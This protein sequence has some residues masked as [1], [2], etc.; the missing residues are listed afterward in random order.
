MA[1]RPPVGDPSYNKDE[2]WLLNKTL[3]G[4]RWSP[5]HRYNMIT[6]IL[7]KMGMAP[8][9]HYPYIYSGV[10]KLDSNQTPSSPE[11]PADATTSQREKIHVGM[12]VDDFIFYST[13]PEEEQRFKRS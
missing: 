1:I 4:L 3:Y 9:V 8:S 11:I 12:Y 13:D 7:Q 2:Y 10:V 5:H 6:G